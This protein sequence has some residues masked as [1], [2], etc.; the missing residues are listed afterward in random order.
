MEVSPL[1]RYR[2]LPRHGKSRPRV[3]AL[4]RT[5]RPRIPAGRRCPAHVRNSFSSTESP[6]VVRRSVW[7]CSVRATYSVWLATSPLWV[8]HDRNSFRASDRRDGLTR[9]TSSRQSTRPCCQSLKVVG[10]SHPMPRNYRPGLRSLGL[11]AMPRP[12]WRPVPRVWPYPSDSLRPA[13]VATDGN[14]TRNV[15]P[16][17]PTRARY[18]LCAASSAFR[19]SPGSWLRSACGG[20]LA[21]PS[22]DRCRSRCCGR[23]PRHGFAVPGVL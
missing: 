19:S 1:R 15:I 4:R 23:S 9:R 12:P 6:L 3:P 14:A 22:R 11:Q 16:P 10:L 18:P 20:C 13:S 2:R 17:K 7:R 8:A 5:R 21:F